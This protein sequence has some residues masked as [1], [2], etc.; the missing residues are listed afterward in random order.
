MSQFNAIEYFE[1]S[2]NVENYY[3]PEFTLQRRPNSHTMRKVHRHSSQE[4]V[5]EITRPE[6]RDG[7]YV[8]EMDEHLNE[9]V[10]RYN[11]NQPLE[12]VLHKKD[13]Y[14]RF[15]FEIE[16]KCVE[17]I[18]SY[19]KRTEMNKTKYKVPAIGI[20]TGVSSYNPKYKSNHTNIETI[21]KYIMIRGKLYPIGKY[22]RENGLE[23][24]EIQLPENYFSTNVVYE[25]NETSY[26]PTK[27]NFSKDTLTYSFHHDMNISSIVMRGELMKFKKVSGDN[28]ISKYDRMNPHLF[29]KMKYHID[30]LENDPGFVSKFQMFYR[31]EMTNGQWVNH[32]TF[33]G[34][35]SATDSTKICFDEIMAKE[36][37]IVP[38]SMYKSCENIR[39][40]FIGKCKVQ[41]KSDEI[42][43]TYEVSIP[44]NGKYLKYSS[45]VCDSNN[46]VSDF[47]D[48][49]K[50]MMRNKKRYNRHEIND[51]IKYSV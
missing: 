49:K 38:I 40:N 10:Y 21:Q 13:L 33:N 14:D 28:K 27:V 30:I 29:R 16:E 17:K 2:D 43:V 18:I 11:Y 46:Y 42:F 41:P 1:I 26:C 36:I 39:I 50:F 47:Q 51:N 19:D 25:D 24:S 34:N 20:L 9:K 37:R 48:D 23:Y 12:V 8:T 6:C 35:V 5:V 3:N 44:R 31:S 7:V 45:K 4:Y 32:G 22:F 15:I